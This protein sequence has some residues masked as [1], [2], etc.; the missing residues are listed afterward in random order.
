MKISNLTNKTSL[1]I[2]DTDLLVIEDAEGTKS[3]TVK[4][5]RDYLINQGVSKNTKL[6]INNMLDSV[7]NSLKTSKYIITELLTYQ[8]AATVNE[9]KSIYI[10]F[11]N[12]ETDEWLTKQ[13]IMD[14]LVPNPETEMFTKKFVIRVLVNGEY[15]DSTDYSIHDGHELDDIVPRN[16]VGYIKADFYD[17]TQNEIAGI[18]Y[19]DIIITVEDTEITIT[20][21]VE[22]VHS[23]EFIGNPESFNNNVSYTQEI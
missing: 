17:L 22:D 19:S 13:E 2:Q 21:P 11:K 15:I 23:Y 20:L 16:L 3:V 8:M 10:K 6:L 4:E 7:I 5:F 18:T 9:E 1:E 14:I 12:P